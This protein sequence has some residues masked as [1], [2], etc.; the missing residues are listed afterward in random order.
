[1]KKK[2]SLKSL[3]VAWQGDGI[4]ICQ[5]VEV[6]GFKDEVVALW[7]GSTIQNEN[8]KFKLQAIRGE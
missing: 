3:G 4:A 8:S 6:M 7:R 1:M 5:K 2:W